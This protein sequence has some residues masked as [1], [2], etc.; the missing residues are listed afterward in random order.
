MVELTGVNVMAFPEDGIT[1]GD[2]VDYY[3]R[4]AS[5]MLPHLIDRPLAL[6]FFPEGLEHPA[7][8]QREIPDD[9]P[10]WI[11]R[12]EVCHGDQ[13]IFQ[14]ICDEPAAL[15][16][17]A[18]QGCVSFYPWLSRIDLPEQPD[19]MIFGLDPS[20]DRFD[21]LITAAQELR[22]F[23][24]QQFEF[25]AYAMTTGSHGLHV[26]VPLDRSENFDS[27]AEFAKD[28]AQIVA[29]QNSELITLESEN[30][31]RAGKVF[32]DTNRN[33]YSQTMIAP[34]CVRALEG[35][36]VARPIFWSELDDSNFNPKIY[37]MKN[38][39]LWLDPKSDPWSGMTRRAR[40][41]REAKQ[42]IALLM[43]HNR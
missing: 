1:R 42:S 39:S 8:W 19:R 9:F 27:V 25:T 23:L 2:L 6:E 21:L 13:K 34:Y 29:E 24:K 38:V 7:I 20:D 5:V 4:V 36:P 31:L 10:D 11:M 14:C 3:R 33:T 26:V 17:L 35:A 32:L 43:S 22:D 28:V 16:W 40:S 30:E 18:D 12:V 41:L 15:V 37:G